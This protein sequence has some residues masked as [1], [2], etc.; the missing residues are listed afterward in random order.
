MSSKWPKIDFSNL[1]KSSSSKP[2]S[3]E[4]DLAL[5]ITMSPPKLATVVDQQVSSAANSMTSLSGRKTVSNLPPGV[6]PI[7]LKVNEKP[8]T[9]SLAGSERSTSSPRIKTFDTRATS[10]V[11]KSSERRLSRRENA[12]QSL[13]K[14]SEKTRSTPSQPTNN[15]EI[16]MPECFVPLVDIFQT[17]VKRNLGL[18]KCSGINTIKILFVMAYGAAGQLR[19]VMVI[20]FVSNH[21][22]VPLICV[23]MHY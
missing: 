22:S 14:A 5:S 4:D 11:T 13:S 20:S 15:L 1:P 18:E 6:T 12:S 3:L 19:K 16:L 2:F 8:M 9:T 23:Y 17:S 10:R 7:R 21:I